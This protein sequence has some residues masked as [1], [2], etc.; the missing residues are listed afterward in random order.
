MYMCILMHN[1]NCNKASMYLL[2]KAV[3]YSI[4]IMKI[5]NLKSGYVCQ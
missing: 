3:W 1:Y 4:I 5:N 2:T